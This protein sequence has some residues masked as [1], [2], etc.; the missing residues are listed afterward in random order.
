MEHIRYAVKVAG[1][2]IRR[3]NSSNYQIV[4]FEKAQLH[5]TRNQAEYKAKINKGEV[6]EVRVAHNDDIVLVSKGQN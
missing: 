2:Y 5:L 1:G 6:V 4:P 3:S